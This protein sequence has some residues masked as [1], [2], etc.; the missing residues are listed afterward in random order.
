MSAVE[1]NDDEE[2]TRDKRD[3]DGGDALVTA[4]TGSLIVPANCVVCVTFYFT[5]IYWL[6]TEYGDRNGV[7]YS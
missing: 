1:G 7:L 5:H 6:Q 3:A 4:P 2:V